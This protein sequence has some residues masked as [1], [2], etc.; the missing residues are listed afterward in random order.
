MGLASLGGVQKKLE[1]EEGC[2]RLAKH[3]IILFL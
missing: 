3:K 2:G 1:S